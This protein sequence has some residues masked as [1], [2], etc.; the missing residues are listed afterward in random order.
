MRQ[1]PAVKPVRVM[2]GD[3]LAAVVSSE[4]GQ[5]TISPEPG[6]RLTRATITVTLR[7]NRP[8]NPAPPTPPG[9]SGSS[10][11]QEPTP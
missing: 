7:K 2:D 11:S 1:P 3:Q 6:Y 9:S 5:I 8:R 10:D 4:A